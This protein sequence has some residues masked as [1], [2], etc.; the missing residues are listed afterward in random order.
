MTISRDEEMPGPTGAALL[1]K[2]PLLTTE[3]ADEFDCICAALSHEI[4]PNGI[5]EV[6][7]R[8]RA[9]CL[10]NSAAAALQSFDHKP[11][12]S[13]SARGIG[14]SASTEPGPIQIPVER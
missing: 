1:P 10:G 9:A 2:T 12:V 11:G 8:H 4:R 5:I 7:G 14:R 3:S 13:R 6:R